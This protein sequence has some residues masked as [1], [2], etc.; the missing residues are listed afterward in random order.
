MVAHEKLDQGAIVGVQT[1]AARDGVHHARA[2]LRMTAAETLA[3]IVKHQAKI[4]QLDLLGFARQLGEQ[5]QALGVIAGF[6][7]FDLFDQ[8]Q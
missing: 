4:K 1:H 3:D 5:R 2:D 8:S 6:Q 7:P